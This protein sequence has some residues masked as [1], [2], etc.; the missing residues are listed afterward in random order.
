M[1]FAKR[2]S[3]NR[4]LLCIV[5]SAL[6]LK[7][8]AT[9]TIG[10]VPI[11]AIYDESNFL[12]H[13]KALLLGQWLG[14]YTDLTL[15]KGPGMELYI[16]A[17]HQLGIP[18]PLAHQL[19][20]ASASLLAI[21][22]IRPVVRNSWVLGLI[23]YVLL[24]NP[25]TFWSNSWAL[26]RSQLTNTL[27][28][29]YAACA[30][31]TIFRSSRGVAA[32][33]IW[34]T[35]TGLAAA[36]ILL[37]REDTVWV[38]PSLAVFLAIYVAAVALDGRPNR[39]AR[40]A[41]TAIPPLVLATPVVIIMAINGSV[42]GWRTTV[43]M[44]SPEFVSAYQ[45]LTRI[46]VPGIDNRA[47]P[48]SEAA[49]EAAYGASKAAA[50]LKPYFDVNHFWLQMSCAPPAQSPCTDMSGAWLVWAFRDAVAGAGYYTTG[51][52]ARHY[53]IRLSREL[54]AACDAGTLH[55]RRKSFGL[56]PELHL[57]DVPGTL[58]YAFEALWHAT[59]YYWFALGSVPPLSNSGEVVKRDYQTVAGS[60]VG[61]TFV[62]IGWLAHERRG[63]IG[64]QSPVALDSF[65]LEFGPSADIRAAFGS[66]AE[67]RNDDLDRA[68][69]VIATSCSANCLLVV[70]DGPGRVAHIPLDVTRPDFR[71]PGIAYHLESE[72]MDP[73][74]FAGDALKSNMLSEIELKHAQLVPWW[75]VLV[76]T[77]VVTR[78]VRA[79]RGKRPVRVL[80]P[81][82][83]FLGIAMALFGHCLVL[84]LVSQV[85]FY[86]LYPEYQAPLYPLL[87][88]CLV[89]PT[90]VESQIIYRFA[91]RKFRRMKRFTG[92]PA[93]H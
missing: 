23:Y 73:P 12:E 48:A 82:F 3:E 69:F 13:A 4:T 16:A 56:A 25:S 11:D 44:T 74:V 85:S 75:V 52:A 1:T 61:S 57:S 90:A 50:E 34:M 87:I 36:A 17:M 22:A 93:R 15:I 7:L 91:F 37:T 70:D 80:L 14:T 86:A 21:L 2:A 53:Y 8:W 51:R 35:G 28:L 40:V 20:Y 92:A 31:G 33:V 41:L 89:V 78:C 30:V 19:I 63:S 18:I 45:S 32:V 71:Q 76:A 58:R 43:E 54:D 29:A 60:A 46:L 77:L 68:R 64:L 10:I 49:R 24:F 6:V 79:M 27:S 88:F 65:N 26:N 83:G 42:Y 5:V 47:Y 39:R 59:T 81:Y 72:A 62:Y 38:F 55:C 66:S 67:F 84:G 9:S